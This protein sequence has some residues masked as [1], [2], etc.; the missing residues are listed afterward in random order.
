M[1]KLYIKLM[2]EREKLVE[3]NTKDLHY[4]SGMMGP[5]GVKG[6]TNNNKPKDNNKKKCQCP[7]LCLNTQW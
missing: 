4:R 7:T 6:I 3:D 2:E 5:A 1:Q